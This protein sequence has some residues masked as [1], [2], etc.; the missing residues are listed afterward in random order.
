MNP[1]DPRRCERHLLAAAI[2]WAYG[3]GWRPRWPE[4]RRREGMRT[5]ANV[6][7][8]RSLPPADALRVTLDGRHLQVTRFNSAAGWVAIATVEAVSVVQVVDVLAA[9]GILPPF[10]SSAYGLA[11]DRYREQVE[12]LIEE[13]ER[14]KAAFT[15]SVR[16]LLNQWAGQPDEVQISALVEWGGAS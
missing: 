11:E 12:T 2:R 15:T 9:L 8:T 14:Q 1:I 13:L 7:W 3:D 5:W 4:L 10:L 16:G 6:R